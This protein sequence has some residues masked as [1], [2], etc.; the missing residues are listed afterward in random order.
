M[1]TALQEVSCIADRFFITEPPRKTHIQSTACKIPGWMTHKM[2]SRF[3]GEYQQCQ[4]H[5]DTTLVPENE[6]DLKS[7]LMK[8]R[9]KS[10]KPGLKLNVQNTKIMASG[11]IK[12]KENEVAQ[13]CTTLC[14][15]MDCSPPGFSVH[16]IL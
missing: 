12:G 5:N 4:I 14:D 1:S 16:G 8:I 13:S 6:K 11:P 7:I 15:P 10:E 9:D 3:P 2:E